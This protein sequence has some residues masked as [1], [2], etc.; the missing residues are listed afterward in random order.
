MYD[1]WIFVKKNVGKTTLLTLKINIL[2]RCFWNQVHISQ[3]CK[4]IWQIGL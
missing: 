4:E 2:K 1:F 3:R